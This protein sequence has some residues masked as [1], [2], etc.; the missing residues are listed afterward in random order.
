MR[1]AS[2]FSRCRN[3]RKEPTGSAPA[4]CSRLPTFSS[5]LAR[6]RCGSSSPG[7][8]LTI[9]LSR[10]TASAESFSRALL[11]ISQRARSTRELAGLIG[12]SEAAISKH[13]K[14]LQEAGWIAPVRESYYVLYHLDR[15]PVADLTH[16]L[17]TVLQERPAS[18]ADAPPATAALRTNNS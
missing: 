5:A 1:S 11:S 17:K 12:V 3:M 9:S 13:L 6:S 18:P 7:E 16:G 4:D 2:H 15:T 14:Q 10:L 8:E